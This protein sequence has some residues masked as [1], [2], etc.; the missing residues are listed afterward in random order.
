MITQFVRANETTTSSKIFAET[1]PPDSLAI[2]L[3]ISQF[4]KL[5]SESQ[6]LIAPPLPSATLLENS[7]LMRM[8]FPPAASVPIPPPSPAQKLLDT[9]Q[10]VR[11]SSAPLTR[12]APPKV[13]WVLAF[14]RTKFEIET[15]EALTSK[16]RVSLSPEIVMRSSGPEIVISVVI[17][18]SP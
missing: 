5:T 6:L 7:L 3:K 12:M 1:P 10:F 8:R 2:L 15:V 11:V 17:S 4:V 16:I 14:V 18:N 13:S 9:S